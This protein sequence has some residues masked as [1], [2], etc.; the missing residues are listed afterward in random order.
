MTYDQAY[1]DHEYLWSIGPAADMSGGY[2]DQED[3]D[4]LLKSPTKRT[5]KDCLCSQIVYWFQ[6]GPDRGDSHG[7]DTAPLIENDPTVRDIAERHRH[8]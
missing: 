8:L 3:L 7:Q 1:K 6:I 2:V 5:A 4:K